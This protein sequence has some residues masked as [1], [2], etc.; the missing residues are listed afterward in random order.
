MLGAQGLRGQYVG[1][2]W[3][4]KAYGEW[5]EGGK[6]HHE[7][8]ARPWEPVRSETGPSLLG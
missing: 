4:A 1:G 3:E 5:V 7:P 6:A 2:A 8:R